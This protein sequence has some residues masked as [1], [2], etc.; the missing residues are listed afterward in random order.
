MRH[1]FALGPALALAGVIELRL[2]LLSAELAHVSSLPVPAGS[3]P[4]AFCRNCRRLWRGACP[5]SI[6]AL[7]LNDSLDLRCKGVRIPDHRRLPPA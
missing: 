5:L 1:A 4:P 2:L 7:A 6:F 3:R